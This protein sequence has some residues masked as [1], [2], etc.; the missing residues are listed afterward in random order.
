[1]RGKK[2]INKLIFLYSFN[3]GE[4]LGGIPKKILKYSEAIDFVVTDTYFNLLKTLVEKKV[5]KK[6]FII[7]KSRE[8][9]ARFSEFGIYKI[10]NN[11]EIIYPPNLSA[12][13]S[14]IGC[15]NNNDIIWARGTS[16]LWE[17]FLLRHMHARKVL[18]NLAY[19]NTDVQ[20]YDLIFGDEDSQF[21]EI[22][23]HKYF[24]ELNKSANESIFY[25]INIEKKYDLISIGTISKRKG[26]LRLIRAA[27]KLNTLIRIALP[28]VCRDDGYKEKCIN[29][30]KKSKLELYFPGLV[31]RTQLNLLIS[32]SRLHVLA[33]RNEQA[34][35][36]VI[37]ASCC[38]IPSVITHRIGGGK[39][40]INKKTG[41]ISH[42]YLLSRSIK[43]AL[44]SDYD[45]VRES[46]LEL[47]GV[48]MASKKVID[49][50]KK[51]GWIM[52]AG[53]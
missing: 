5:I 44:E 41:L 10:N 53:E 9:S 32:Q 3:G 19:L 1:M 47:F 50:F 46:Y 24:F 27:K 45:S 28:G 18:Y 12:A 4:V 29:L 48:E 30:A 8:E 21:K 31:S 52:A 37:E 14:Y 2:M 39:N 43:K 40:Y 36:S 34:P 16:K 35:R 38:G 26:Q 13:E 22:M 33:S 23:N 7:V 17:Q 25:P 15:I 11:I 42:E 51:K 49:A 6:L 20:I